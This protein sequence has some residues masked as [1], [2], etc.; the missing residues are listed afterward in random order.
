MKVGR[1]IP[2]APWFERPER[3]VRD[4]APYLSATSGRGYI[5]HQFGRPLREDSYTQVS[6]TA[7]TRWHAALS[8]DTRLLH[9]PMT[10]PHSIRRQLAVL[11]ALALASCAA[12]SPATWSHAIEQLTADDVAHPPRPGGIVFVGSSSIV[13][14]ESLFSDFAGENVVKRGF[15]GSELADSVYYADRIVIPYQPRTVVLYAGD[16][17]LAAGKSPDKVFADFQAFVAKVHA[18]LPHCRIVYIAA[19]PSPS[20]WQLRD[21]FERTNTLI[22]EACAKDPERLRLVDV[23]HPMLGADGTPRPELFLPDKLHMNATGYAI[24]TPL[25]KAAL[26]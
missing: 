20:R 3:R 24:W 5:N 13:K 2:N 14:W 19:K 4:N 22:A 7:V 26:K 6:E 10:L 21:K 18:A 8:V 15:G 17:D 9:S 16:N 1:V 25:V 23:W 12:A 11:I